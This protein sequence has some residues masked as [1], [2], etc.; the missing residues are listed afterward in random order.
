[1]TKKTLFK[2][3]QSVFKKVVAGALAAITLVSAMSATADAA[4][5][6][7]VSD[8]F[9]SE[10]EFAET[11]ESV[12]VPYLDQYKKTGYITGKKKAKLYY[13]TYVQ[14]N[15]KGTIVISHGLTE[16][17]EKY[18]EMIYYFL[19]MGYNVYGMEHRGHSRSGR[20]GRDAYQVNVEDFS[21]YFKDLKTFLDEVVVPQA[22]KKN[23]YLFAHSMGGGIATRFLEEYP[24]YF[25]AAILSAPMLEIQSGNVPPFFAKLLAHGLSITPFAD[26]YIMG[27]GVYTGEYDFTNC[28][29]SSEARYKRNWEIRQNNSIL[30]MGG[31]SYQWLSECYHATITATS[32]FEAS[33]V[34]VPVILFQ[35][36]K[37]TLVGDSGQNK[38]AK[39]AK[40]CTL[41]R[42]DNAKHEI[43]GESDEIL[44]DYLNKVFT[45]LGNN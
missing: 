38:F 11:M 15:A 18:D 3:T 25:Q 33:K 24:K 41:V 5:A 23:L 34:K 2:N 35:A 14:E 10:N 31:S 17:L 40:N 29:T 8:I 19:N 37:D 28:N 13:E 36:G 32:L 45:F 4:K 6:K 7:T 20:L 1:M 44:F 43:Y 27:Q 42:Y 26:K 12:V 30:Q 21:Y 9:I 16:S 22:T 39:Y